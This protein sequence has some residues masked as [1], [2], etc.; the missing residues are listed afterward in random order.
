MR[1]IMKK[2]LMILLLAL[3]TINLNC[4]GGSGTSTNVS[5]KTTVT[6]N[7]GETRTASRAGGLLSATSTIPSVVVS[8]RFV[9]SAPDM[10]TIERIVSVAGKLVIT[11]SFEIPNGTNRDFLVEAMDVSGNVV[12]RGE[13]FS[14]LDGRPLT[15]II[16][17]VSTD[18]TPPN[19]SGISSINSITTTSMMLSWSAA[20]DNVTPQGNIQYLIYMS[21]SSGGE[22]FASP[23]FTTTPG[24]TSFNVTGLNPD[25]IYYFVV[26]AMD[27]AGNI[28]TNTVEMS[29]RT[30]MLPDVTPPTF[31]GLVS[32]TAVSPTQISLQWNPASD[33]RTLA[34]NIVYLVYRATTSS[35]ENL[36]VPNFTTP[37]GATSFSITGLSPGTTYY[38][39]VRAKDAAGNIDS[40]T[41]EKSATTPSLLADLRP[42]SPFASTTPP[43]G[44]SCEVTNTGTVDAVDV[45]VWVQYTNGCSTSCDS[46][47]ISVPA[48]GTQSVI[49]TPIAFTPTQYIIIVDPNN[50]IPESNE[51]NNC[52]SNNPTWCSSPPPL[53]CGA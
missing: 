39:I 42:V 27:E 20:T 24:A 38:F 7:L 10:A 51:S 4:G 52:V 47:T 8:I 6:I 28:D 37:P 40:N 11:E 15:L 45:E 17:M 41:V 23:S 48:G 1:T 30:L 50:T 26:R 5:G 32:A 43:Y 21:T 2:L 53:L 13:T 49:D 16:V 46:F 31:G 35:V 12:F 25:T 19:F 14:N 9:I 33:D 34:A 29:E 44:V 22:N 18:K 3:L 36:S